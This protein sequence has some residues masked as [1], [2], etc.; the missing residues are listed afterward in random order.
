[1]APARPRWVAVG[2]AAVLDARE[3]VF[4]HCSSRAAAGQPDG[5]RELEADP[6]MA[7]LGRVTET[8]CP[9]EFNQ[10]ECCSFLGGELT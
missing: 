7:R 9:Y 3:R 8:F 2:R 1:M 6:V 10:P 4:E 5:L